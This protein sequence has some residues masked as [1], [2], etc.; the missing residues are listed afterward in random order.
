MHSVPNR[1]LL[2]AAA[3]A[4]QMCLGI[5]YAWAVFRI[6][7]E[8]AYG[9][10][11]TM[12]IAPYRWSILF[13]T[14]AM[15]VAGFWQDRKGPRLVASVGGLL[16]GAGCLL[17]SFIGADHSSLVFSYGVVSG[18]GVGFAYV[19]PIA[20]CVKWFPDKR[21]FVVGLA[22]MGFGMGS[23]IFAPLLES[24]LG[25]DPAL[26]ATTLPRTFLIL[27]A[28]FFVVVIGCA[29]LFQ[30]PPAG[31]KPAGWNPVV[32]GG[33]AR[34]EFGPAAMLKTWQFWVVWVVYF[35]ASS[36]GLTAIGEAAPLVR[37]LAGSS[38]LMTA[39]AALGVMSLFNGLGRLGWGAFSDRA[40]YRTAMLCTATIATATCALL[41]PGAHTFGIVL[42]GICLVG[43]CY[44]G[45]LA[46]MPAITAA[47][48]GPRHIGANYGILFTAWGAAG[49]VVPRFCAAIIER[50]KAAGTLTAG[51]DQVFYTLAGLAAVGIVAAALIRRP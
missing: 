8:Q 27:S 9:W 6:P 2:A 19:T 33:L 36:V 31:W 23:L 20:T 3:V 22:V 39:G 46:V 12:S 40:G 26:Y 4:M 1:W 25:K 43:F 28:I 15:I 11:K 7:L 47:F 41:L 29:Q 18:L 13:F 17:A 49:F 50:A 21:G 44:G 10:S 51:Y 24:M 48:F 42:L 30:V 35:L 45:A 38:M 32:T 34:A 14:L 37:E 5:I 16:L